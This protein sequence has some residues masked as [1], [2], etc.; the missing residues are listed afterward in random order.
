[1]HAYYSGN[2][3]LFRLLVIVVRIGVMC[4]CYRFRR[5]YPGLFAYT[6]VVGVG[7]VILPLLSVSASLEA[8][9]VGYWLL[10]LLYRLV[11]L[12]ILRDIFRRLFSPYS[13][14]PRGTVSVVTMLLGIIVVLSL[15]VALV[16]RS[17]YPLLAWLMGADASLSFVLCGAIV[18]MLSVSKVLG[19]PW[20]GATSF[21]GI[22]FIAQSILV[23]VLPT[24]AY[25]PGRP[26]L[27][28]HM[29]EIASI[30]AAIVWVVG[31]W[32]EGGVLTNS[33]RGPSAEEKREEDVHFV[34]LAYGEK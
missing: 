17:K 14:L 4:F 23:A 6:A 10:R 7:S 31:L 26:W 2:D 34:K 5:R 3:Y 11:S 22:G 25:I 21:I 16:P 18:V 19:L 15:I 32:N 27:F 12:L 28:G 8:Y 13:N 29:S 30:L 1:M 24:V 9:F 20:T 33:G